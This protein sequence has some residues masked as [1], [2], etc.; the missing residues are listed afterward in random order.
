MDLTLT[1]KTPKLESEV[2]VRFLLLAI[3][4]LGNFLPLE[5]KD[6]H[7]GLSK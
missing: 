6:N 7:K 3:V 1:H 5:K 4:P 2:E